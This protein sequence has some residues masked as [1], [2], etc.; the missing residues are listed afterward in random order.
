MLAAQRATFGDAPEHAGGFAIAEG[1]LLAAQDRL[2]DLG[3]L[4]R[5]L[6]PLLIDPN[7]RTLF[8]GIAAQWYALQGDW[9]A[10][11]HRVRADDRAP[12]ARAAARLSRGGVDDRSLRRVAEPR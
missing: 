2:P 6:A 10:R 9:T 11:A 12:R 8:A 3:A 4:R 7:A 1:F 5:G